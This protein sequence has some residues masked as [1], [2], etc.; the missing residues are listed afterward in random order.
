MLCS[1]SCL[2]KEFLW[3]QTFS[4]SCVLQ[5]DITTIFHE[6]SII[7]EVLVKAL[8]MFHTKWRPKSNIAA[9]T[10][11]HL[12]MLFVRRKGPLTAVN[13]QSHACSSTQTGTHTQTHNMLSAAATVDCTSALLTVW[14]IAG[15]ASPL[16]F[17][18]LQYNN[19]HWQRTVFK[20]FFA[21][22]YFITYI[23]YILQ[24]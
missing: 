21:V 19:C 9:Q 16:C 24:R 17:S 5:F 2:I 7:T 23:K 12:V 15:R 6:S 18:Q 11:T 3:L 13:E 22:V 1:L 8:L 10:H 20:R 4:V 14:T